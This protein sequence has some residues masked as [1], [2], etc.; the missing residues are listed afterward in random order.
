MVKK[1]ILIFISIFFVSCSTYNDK[2]EFNNDQSLYDNN[3][4]KDY[5]L[6]NLANKYIESGLLDLALIELDKI[7]V[8][9]PSSPFAK[10][11]ILITAYINFLKKDY[12]KTRALA[13]MYKNYYPGSKDIVY[14]NYLEAMSYYVVM[15]KSD[16]SQYSS[17][18]ALKKFNFILNAYPNSQYEIDIITKIRTINDNLAANKLKI[19]KYYN[20]RDNNNGSLLYLNDIFTNHSSS[21]SIEET[22]YLMC[23]IYFS[24]DEHDLAKKYASILAHN[25]PN[26]E[27]YEKSYNII[28]GLE[29]IRED[30]SWF[31]KLNPIKIIKQK[32]GNNSNN[33]SIQAIE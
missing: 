7:E 20:E 28:N 15:K 16:Y 24:I 1:Q 27:W 26:S 11:S 10:K 3:S 18:I 12:E 22:L 19:A 25:F 17:E 6:F 30:K 5:E 9:Y 31:E 33:I 32:R 14:A 21:F 2:D 13:E 4:L 8:L 29:E 23:K